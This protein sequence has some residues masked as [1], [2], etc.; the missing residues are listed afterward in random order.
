MTTS[1][2]YDPQCL[3]KAEVETLC[4]TKGISFFSK[5]FST[6]EKTEE[7]PIYQGVGLDSHTLGARDPPCRAATGR[8]VAPKNG[9]RGVDF[10]P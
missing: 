2:S 5:H 1:P 10:R 8:A 3:I 7:V 6:F 4:T 9:D